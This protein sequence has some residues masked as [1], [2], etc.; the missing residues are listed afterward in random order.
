MHS[1]NPNLTPLESL[2]EL[3]EEFRHARHDLNN[4]FTVFLA[5]AELGARNPENY[6]RLG[7]AVL[8]R[9]PKVL[10]DLQRFQDSLF[11]A[12][13]RLQTLEDAHPPSKD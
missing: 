4:V 5:L 8:E 10:E 11:Q 13:A 7:K 1:S 9:C 2:R 6:E 12:E 3:I